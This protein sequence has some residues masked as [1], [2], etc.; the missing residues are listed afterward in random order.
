LKPDGWLSLTARMLLLGTILSGLPLK[1]NSSRRGSPPILRFFVSKG[2][3]HFES[4]PGGFPPDFSLPVLPAKQQSL[5]AEA[6]NDKSAR[7]TVGS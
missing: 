7:L 3:C 6:N 1:T 5:R 2:N 4:P